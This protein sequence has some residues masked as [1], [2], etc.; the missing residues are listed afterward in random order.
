V[1]YL[2]DLLGTAALYDWSA[3][4]SQPPVSTKEEWKDLVARMKDGTVGLVVHVDANPVYHLPALLGYA[5]A[6]KSVP[7]AVSLVESEDE[8]GQLCTY[9]LQ[10]TTSSRAG[11]TTTRSR[12]STRSSS[13]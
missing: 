6:L 11:A 8:T 2:N 7:M 10:S 12:E 4:R 5:D 13:R 9:I 1:N 3:A